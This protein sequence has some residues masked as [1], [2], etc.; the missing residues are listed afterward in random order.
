MNS[1]MVYFGTSVGA[2]PDAERACLASAPE[3]EHAIS[4]I[5][6]LHIFY[7]QYNLISFHHKV[8]KFQLRS[9]EFSKSSRVHK[10]GAEKGLY[11]FLGFSFQDF[12]IPMFAF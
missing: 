2:F 12:H 5:F 10:K 1:N 6:H 8:P 7:I 3:V 11:P 4:D 9:Q